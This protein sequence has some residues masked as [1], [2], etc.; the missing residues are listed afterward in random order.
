MKHGVFIYQAPPMLGKNVMV[1]NFAFM[2]FSF[3]GIGKG[4]KFLE[5]LQKELIKLDYPISVVKDD[6]EANLEEINDRQ[7]DF[8]LLFQYFKKNSFKL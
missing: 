7:Y 3:M 8:I 1:D 2:N 5:K 6:T 4:K